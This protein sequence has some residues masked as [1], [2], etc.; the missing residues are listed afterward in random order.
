MLL[1]FRSNV[2]AGAVTAIDQ[3]NKALSQNDGMFRLSEYDRR[4]RMPRPKMK[5][6]YNMKIVVIGG[7]G[8]IGSKLVAKL[9]AH[10]HQAVAASPN[11][12]NSALVCFRRG[13]PESNLYTEGPI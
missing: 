11:M 10:G 3:N 1:H 5:G 12:R 7:S 8:L 4:L 13:K 6:R 9:G 2:A